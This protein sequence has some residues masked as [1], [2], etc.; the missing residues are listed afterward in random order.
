MASVISKIFGRI[1]PRPEDGNACHE[2]AFDPEMMPKAVRD[3]LE[4]DREQEKAA[5]WPQEKQAGNASA[6]LDY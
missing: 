4:Q 3:K 6:A 5:G 1:F 2:A